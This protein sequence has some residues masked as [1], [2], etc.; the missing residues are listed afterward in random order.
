MFIEGVSARVCT[1]SQHLER[2][3][4]ENCPGAFASRVSLLNSSDL[5]VARGAGLLICS[6]GLAAQMYLCS[7]WLAAPHSGR[8]VRRSSLD[9]CLG[10]LTPGRRLAL[11]DVLLVFLIGTKRDARLDSVHP[12]FRMLSWSMSRQGARLFK[13]SLTSSQF[14]VVGPLG[15]LVAL[16]PCPRWR[17][18]TCLRWFL[19]PGALES[20]AGEEWPWCR[21]CALVTDRARTAHG[22]HVSHYIYSETR[23]FT[24]YMKTK[25]Y[26]IF[27]TH[28]L[29]VHVLLVFSF[30]NVSQMIFTFHLFSLVYEMCP[31]SCLHN[32]APVFTPSF[33]YFHFFAR[34]I[35]YAFCR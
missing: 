32:F 20:S 25:M 19:V 6:R 29:L 7:Q 17:L 31:K 23:I 4:L 1:R 24:T 27:N 28:V 15:V 2:S 8:V 9:G 34:I 3:A 11:V 26:Y 33:L 14:P 12:K 13:L 35:F 21:G 10:A 22:I 5:V 18:R 16:Q 30:S